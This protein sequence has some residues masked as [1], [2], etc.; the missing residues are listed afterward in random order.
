MALGSFVRTV[1]FDPFF[2]AT[3]SYPGEQSLRRTTRRL[4][5]RRM[6]FFDPIH[7]TLI[8]FD[9]YHL[10]SRV[11]ESCDSTPAE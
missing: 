8:D 9:A 2:H 11:A 7:V 1:H 4:V 6:L 3:A 5:Y 10:S